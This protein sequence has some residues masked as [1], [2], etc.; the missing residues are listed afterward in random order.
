MTLEERM[1]FEDVVKKAT[2]KQFPYVDADL[3]RDFAQSLIFQLE[4][5]LADK[6]TKEKQN[7]TK[8]ANS[9]KVRSSYARD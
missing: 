6:A 2:L 8:V 9:Q 3:N 5:F 4:Q 7:K 1:N